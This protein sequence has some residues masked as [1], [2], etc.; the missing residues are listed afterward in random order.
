MRPVRSLAAVV[1]STALAAALASCASPDRTQPGA[2]RIGEDGLRTWARDQSASEIACPAFAAEHPV[3]GV[4]RG[5]PSDTQESIWLE[6]QAGTRLSIVWPGGFRATFEPAIVLR[7]ERGAVVAASGDTVELGQVD[8]FAH[9]GT[10]GDPYIASG[11]LF[12]GCY[13]FVD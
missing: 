2:I 1:V 12:D 6:G 10:Y 8:A 7:D 4:L 5:D 13:P 3:S 9:A 11:I